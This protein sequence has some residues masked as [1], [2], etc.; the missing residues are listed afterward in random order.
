MSKRGERAEELLRPHESLAAQRRLVLESCLL[1]LY[2]TDLSAQR[3]Q[4]A[5]DLKEPRP[6]AWLRP[7][8]ASWPFSTR[9]AGFRKTH[10]NSNGV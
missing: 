6:L 1:S 7:Q 10:K 9:R 2:R 8:N 4:G 5:V 3:R